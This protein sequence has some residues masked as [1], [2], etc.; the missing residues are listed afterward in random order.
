[1]SV[2]RPMQVGVVVLALQLVAGGCGTGALRSEHKNWRGPELE[3]AASPGP[4]TGKPVVAGSLNVTPRSMEQGD[5][6]DLWPDSANWVEALVE[7]AGGAALAQPAAW[8]HVLARNETLRSHWR[9]YQGSRFSHAQAAALKQLS[10]RY[11][12]L[13]GRPEMRPSPEMPSAEALMNRVV[14]ADLSLARIAFGDALVELQVR[15]VSAFHQARFH[16]HSATVLAENVTLSRRLVGVVRARYES[17]PLSTADLLRSQMRLD[18]A[19]RRLAGARDRRR[20]AQLTLGALMVAGPIKPGKPGSRA[21]IPSRTLVRATSNGA[22][23]IQ[24]ATAEL[25]RVE[26]MVELAERVT[27]PRRTLGTTEGR[28]SVADFDARYV[29]GAPYLDELRQNLA[30]SERR[31]G[32]AMVREPAAAQA[33]LA[34]LSDATRRLRSYRS[35]LVPKATKAL[36]ATEAE[37]RV[38]RR[39]YL[40]LDDVH[41]LWL[42]TRLAYFAAI[43]DA[44]IAAAKLQ[45]VLGIKG[46]NP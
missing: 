33:A 2:Q 31:L 25:A 45:R 4:S 1:M 11:Q 38:G 36:N 40:E 17:G 15:F 22:T 24:K 9:R 10:S 21:A 5:V 7:P 23:G 16:A 26:A 43:R 3:F 28:K 6:T 27:R 12:A 37:Y 39:T 29:T 35:S 46:E 8:A 30:A 34:E 13:G 32:Q 19:V 20:A 41:R 18:E 44:H 42:D 14:A